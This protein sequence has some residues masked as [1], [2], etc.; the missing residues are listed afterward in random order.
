TRKGT[1]RTRAAMIC[2]MLNRLWAGVA[3][4]P[5]E[6]RPRVSR[7]G[8]LGLQPG[9][10]QLLEAADIVDRGIAEIL[11]RLADQRG[12]AARGAVDEEGLVLLKGRVVIG[13]FRIGAEFEHA[14][15]HIDGT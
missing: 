8:R 9:I 12:A 5:V 2:R 14:A 11:Q 1:M 3:T 4:A 15:R 7:L 6:L 10:G 13:A